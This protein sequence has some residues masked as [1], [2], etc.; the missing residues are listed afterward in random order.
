MPRRAWRYRHTCF[1]HGLIDSVHVINLRCKRRTRAE[2]VSKNL[3]SRVHKTL[4][5]RS[6]VASDD[7]DP[8]AAKSTR[9]AGPRRHFPPT[10]L[11]PPRISRST[12]RAFPELRKSRFVFTPYAASAAKAR[13]KKAFAGRL[14]PVFPDSFLAR[15]TPSSFGAPSADFPSPSSSL[16]A[17]TPW[18]YTVR[19]AATASSSHRT[20][21]FSPRAPAPVMGAR[22]ASHA[23]ASG[24]CVLGN[25]GSPDPAPNPFA[26][27]SA[28]RAFTLLCA[29]HAQSC[30]SRAVTTS[31]LSTS[32]A[33]AR[34]CER[35][36]SQGKKCSIQPTIASNQTAPP[37]SPGARAAKAWN[38]VQSPHVYPRVP[39]TVPKHER[40][41]VSR[42]AASGSGERPLPFCLSVRVCASG[43]IP[44]RSLSRPSPH[45]RAEDS[46]ART[47]AMSPSSAGHKSSKASTMARA[48]SAQ[49]RRGCAALSRFKKPRNAWRV[50]GRSRAG[51][52]ISWYARDVA[53]AT[54]SKSACGAELLSSSVPS[55]ACFCFVFFK[56]AAAT[57]ALARVARA[58]AVS[59]K[60]SSLKEY[61][62][63]VSVPIK[64]SMS[65]AERLESLA[66]APAFSFFFSALNCFSVPNNTVG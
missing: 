33:I 34:K 46:L 4:S 39:S 2:L 42:T 53:T 19:N 23:D 22:H 59:S 63:P 55:K 18:K 28:S 12:R 5:R 47:P 21:F 3:K 31:P 49:T 52:V 14:L 24:H 37:S 66:S 25:A 35:Q 8:S 7:V 13:K 64:A 57:S 20:I 10:L 58:S 40:H 15:K 6:T 54:S 44:K 38:K 9:P 32:P 62:P 27:R 56:A 41:G 17:P 26:S 1:K 48:P 45:T 29:F 16:G 50:S 65:F 51:E 61:D 36:S 30:A 11:F 43:D 60:L